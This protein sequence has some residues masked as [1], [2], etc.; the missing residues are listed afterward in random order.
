[1]RA[2]GHIRSCNGRCMMMIAIDLRFD[3]SGYADVYFHH[4]CSI[5]PIA[6]KPPISMPLVFA[7][8]MEYLPQS[9]ITSAN[10]F[11][12]CM[13]L[14]F[15]IQSMLTKRLPSNS[16]SNGGDISDAVGFYSEYCAMNNGTTTFTEPPGPPGDST[17]NKAIPTMI[18]YKRDT[19]S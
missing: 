8:K 17:W 3:C 10:M 2:V 18:Y 7:A 1:M 9:P 16:C 12:G 19:D 5:I 6:L 11:G 4:C 15:E 14:A 13:R